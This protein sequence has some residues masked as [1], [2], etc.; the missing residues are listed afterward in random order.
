[1]ANNYETLIALNPNLEK[2][3]M[4]SLLDGVKEVI[5]RHGGTVTAE[6]DIG[7]K[8]FAYTVKKFSTG[9]YYLMYFSAPAEAIFEMERNFNHS[10]DVLKYLT[11]KLDEKELKHSLESIENITP[12]IK[13]KEEGNG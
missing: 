3:N 4:A 10:E 7:K 9:Y 5:A 1:M 12:A 11:L 6:K 2:E 8:K 13:E